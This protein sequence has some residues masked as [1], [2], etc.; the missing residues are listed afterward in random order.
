MQQKR[1]E[2]EERPRLVRVEMHQLTVKETHGFL[3]KTHIVIFSLVKKHM[4]MV[5]NMHN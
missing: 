2:E 1:K 4:E 5:K 3:F